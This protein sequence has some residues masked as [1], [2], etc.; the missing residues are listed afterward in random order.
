MRILFLDILRGVAVL[1]MI[2]YHFFWDLGFFGYIDFS[3]AT[4]GFGLISAQI[5]GSSFIL[6]S[7]FS[8][9][10]SSLSKN[11]QRK[12]WW[13]FIKLLF[14][15]ILISIA[16]LIFDK[17]NFI[18]FGILHLITFCSLVGFILIK[19]KNTYLIFFALLLTIFISKANLQFD[20][21]VYISWIGLNAN[22]PNTNDFYPVLPW[23]IYFLIG[24]WIG[25]IL[26]NRGLK[27]WRW[28]SYQNKNVVNGNISKFFL[29][30]GR[31]SLAIYILH[32]P[33]FFS[34]FLIFNGIVS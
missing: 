23:M 9:N 34:L 21:P 28:D 2:I 27:N 13:R 17:N 33:V 30:S 5:I 32:Q 14:L 18:F 19:I 3:L 26:T 29:L 31:N 24:L 6:I 12:F 8:L 16:T 1:A 7:G 10:L 15:S 22:L 4:T 25:K 20:L 11:F